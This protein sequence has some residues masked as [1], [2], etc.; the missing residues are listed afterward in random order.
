MAGQD[1]EAV[2]SH[3]LADYAMSVAVASGHYIFVSISIA[4]HIFR[5]LPISHQQALTAIERHENEE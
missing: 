4:V 2:K 1:V 3:V 5:G